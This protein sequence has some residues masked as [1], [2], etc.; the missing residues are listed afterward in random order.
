MKWDDAGEE[1]HC[2]FPKGTLTPEAAKGQNSPQG[3][4]RG[5]ITNPTLMT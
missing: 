5:N 1:D 3:V 2:V 4:E